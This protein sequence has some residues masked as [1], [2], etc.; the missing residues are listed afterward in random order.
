MNTHL[1]R[2]GS[3]RSNEHAQTAGIDSDGRRA[4][5]GTGESRD[6][7]TAEQH[8]ITV[9]LARRAWAGG[10]DPPYLDRP[11]LKSVVIAEHTPEQIIATIYLLSL[12]RSF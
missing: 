6:E 5:A 8:K 12:W 10:S 11:I 9:A 1:Y 7:R 2:T 4:R 3:G